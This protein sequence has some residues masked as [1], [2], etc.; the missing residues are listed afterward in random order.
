M[1][2]QESELDIIIE[3]PWY[4]SWWAWALYVLV[5]ALM[6]LVWRYALN[7]TRQINL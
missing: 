5:L 2:E 7:K 4:L 1:G 3:S 6:F